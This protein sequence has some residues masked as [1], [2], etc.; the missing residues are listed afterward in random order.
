MQSTR[1]SAATATPTSRL[2]AHLEL[3]R[4]ANMAT[5]LADVL[6]GFAV[7]G[8]SGPEKLP[9]LL[10]AGLAL[11]GGGV[12][13]NDF[14]DR[15][16]DAVERPERPIPSGRASA[17]SACQLGVCLLLFGIACAFRASAAS[18]MVAGAIAL[19]AVAYDAA[20]KHIPIAGPVAMGSCRGLDLLLGV[21]ANANALAT[22]WHLAA[23]P[24]A[25]I[26]GVTLLSAGEVHGGSR[27]RACVSSAL[28]IAAALG[29]LVA[30]RSS[31]LRVASTGFFL[32]LLAWRVAPAFYKAC[33]QPSA[34]QVRAAVRAGVISL[35]L[36]DAA[37]A[38]AWQAL[39][40]ALGLV[41][42]V[43]LVSRLARLFPVT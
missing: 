39:W 41:A 17:R 23:I 42:L 16:L 25:Y 5:A 26:A 21:S 28:L 8:L 27:L 18:G 1:T 38:A 32:G 35:V 33:V 31:P 12:T 13:M 29:A 15:R 9:W 11:Y 7:A 4:P 36:L 37:V 14:F 22:Y 30:G 34:A 6:A 3:M 20:L 43:L 2:R 19:M 24:L 40:Y 10:L